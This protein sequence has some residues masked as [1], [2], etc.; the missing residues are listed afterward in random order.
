MTTTTLTPERPAPDRS[1]EHSPQ[2]SPR[3]LLHLFCTSP[4]VAGCARLGHFT[5]GAM[6]LT[7]GTLAA[8]AAARAENDPAGSR[9]AM[10]TILRQPFGQ[11]L[12]G[13]IAA[14]LAG[15][16]LWQLTRAVRL[17]KPARAE[18]RESRAKGWWLRIMHLGR[19]VF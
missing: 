17:R 3:R 1:P 8:L 6:Y 7:I 15:F 9:G 13:A 4:F 19:A 12:L 5:K 10:A 18:S 14:G 2:P 16:A 11:V